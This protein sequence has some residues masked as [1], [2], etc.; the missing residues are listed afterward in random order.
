MGLAHGESRAKSGSG[1]GFGRQIPA[2]GES[3]ARIVSLD[4]IW[5][6]IPVFSTS[7]GLA[8]W[9]A[10]QQL[11]LITTHQANASGLTKHALTTRC[12]NGLLYRVHH[13]V[14]LF[15]QPTFLPGAREFA[16]ILACGE[17]AVVSHASA[18][19]LY[20]LIEARHGDVEIT[21][22]SRNG[23]RRA[24][25]RIHRVDALHEDDRGHLRGIPIVSPARALLDFAAEATGDELERGI[26]EAYALR[27]TTENEI[28]ATI[29]R[30][31]T[32]HGVAVLRAELRRE[33][34]P[35]WTQR[36][37]ERR[38]K[39]LLRK[40]DLPT[41]ATQHWVAGYPADFCWPQQRLI[42]EVDGY[43]FHSHRS[44][45]ERDRKRDQAH[46]LAGYRVIR[47]TWRHLDEEPLTVVATIAAA[48]SASRAEH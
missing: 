28:N 6:E 33:G 29:A 42:V 22:A 1:A 24:G 39:L 38:T 31:P 9:V 34:G 13:T 43:Q 15:G 5:R 26:A 37:A 11:H 7:D 48:L 30:N 45:F 46:I 2:D 18:A 14:Y 32:R 27:M 21:V 35:A 41:P 4:E 36:E 8:S 23:R 3:Y 47:I 44:A 19:G 40:A 25:I 20:G 12:K 16:A 10:S 17:D